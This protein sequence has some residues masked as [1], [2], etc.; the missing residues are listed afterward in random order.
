MYIY[1]YV[2]TRRENTTKQ[3]YKSMY[4]DKCVFSNIQ[5]EQESNFFNAL[6]IKASLIKDKKV[7]F[8]RIVT[9]K[10]C[11]MPPEGKK[12]NG[13]RHMPVELGCVEQNQRYCKLLN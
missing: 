2:C 8:Y 6:W 1:I 9:K 3:N 5:I 4:M 10:F 7:N 11:F 12:N 13:C